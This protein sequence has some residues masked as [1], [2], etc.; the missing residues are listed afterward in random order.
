MIKIAFC[1]CKELQRFMY[2][3]LLRTCKPDKSFKKKK[4][5]AFTQFVKSD[6]LSQDNQNA[7][8]VYYIF[9]YI[10]RTK[11]KRL[12]MGL[13]E[14]KRNSQTPSV[15]QGLGTS[16]L[17]PLWSNSES[18]ITALFKTAGDINTTKGCESSWLIYHWF[19]TWLLPREP[20]T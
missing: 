1:N 12:I 11:T 18:H 10:F 13:V 17:L 4:G 6:P 16:H 2:K 3:T 7:I 15:E 14:S 5:W 20:R 8:S 9:Y 19:E